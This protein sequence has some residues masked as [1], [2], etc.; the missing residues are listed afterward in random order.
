MKHDYLSE[1]GEIV[2]IDTSK[3]IASGGEGVIYIHPKNKAKAIKIY[4]NSRP[5]KF[6]I[7]FQSLKQLDDVYYV[8]P[9]TV[10]FDKNNQVAGFIMRYIDLNK[11]IVFKK[12]TAKTFCLQ[13]GFDRQFKYKI[14]QNLKRAVENAHSKGIVIGDLNPYNIFFDKFA[15]IVLVDV[16]S[17]ATKTKPHNGVLLEDIRDYILHPKINKETDAYAFDVLISWIFTY[18]HPFRGTLSGYKNLEER[19]V[20]KVSIFG[21]IPNLIIPNCYEPFQNQQTIN[22]LV[23]I[24][25][26]GKR[27]FLDL[28][29]NV[30][31]LRQVYQPL[32]MNSNE[33]YI[34][35]LETNVSQILVSEKLGAFKT[36]N[37]YKIYNLANYGVY[38]QTNIIDMN[39]IDM[40]NIDN[41]FIGNNNV[42]I[43]KEK[44]LYHNQTKIANI[45][46]PE[47]CKFIVQNNTIFVLD[48]ENDKYYQYD[49][50]SLMGGKLVTQINTIF[51]PSVQIND[52]IIQSIGNLSYLFIPNK[53]IYSMVKIDIPNV[54]NAYIRKNVVCLEHIKSNKTEFSFFEIKGTRL[55]Y[56]IDTSDFSYFDVKGDFIFVPKDKKIDLISILRKSVVVTMDCPVSKN[57]SVLFQTNSGIILHTDNNVYHINKKQ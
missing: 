21:N 56:I 46:F 52:A 27:F 11:Y 28:D 34:R 30:Q 51:S 4:H 41:L 53:A 50:D 8:K 15:N 35:L 33:L 7:E 49:I 23:E 6:A 29:N 48:V 57:D 9:E 32:N 17:Y 38:N 5:S 14:Y 31:S 26:N 39:N 2:T 40:N 42:L 44:N 37:G 13:N 18:V 45:E 1:N 47:S 20:K 10:L 55:E 25:Q 3:Q 24:F 54:K 12:L 16:D 19:V 43:L 36:S 22:Q